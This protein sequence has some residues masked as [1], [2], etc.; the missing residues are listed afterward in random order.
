MHACMHVLYINITASIVKQHCT[1]DS[2][3]LSTLKTRNIDHLDD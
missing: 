3:D 1:Y 2:Y